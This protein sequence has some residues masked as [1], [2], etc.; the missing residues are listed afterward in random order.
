M[1]FMAANGRWKICA[2]SSVELA[3]KRYRVSCFFLCADELSDM[4]QN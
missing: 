2:Y 1:P 3:V 4:L